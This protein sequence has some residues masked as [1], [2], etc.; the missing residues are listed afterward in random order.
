VAGRER[1]EFEGRLRVAFE[2]RWARIGW[3]IP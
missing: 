3:G 1:T 2:P